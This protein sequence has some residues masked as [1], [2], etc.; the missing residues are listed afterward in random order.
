MCLWECNVF[1][2]PCLLGAHGRRQ[3][4]LGLS[5]KLKAVLCFVSWLLNCRTTLCRSRFITDVIVLILRKIIT[6]VLKAQR[7]AS[8]KGIN[9]TPTTFLYFLTKWWIYVYKVIV[10]RRRQQEQQQQQTLK[11]WMR[12]SLKQL[13][14]IR[15]LLCRRTPVRIHSS[16]SPYNKHSCNGWVGFNLGS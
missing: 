4:A 3:G 12:L 15:T 10:R 9:L 13:R 16:A 6:W 5:V 1:S 7:G 2:L 8:K 11:A 14:V